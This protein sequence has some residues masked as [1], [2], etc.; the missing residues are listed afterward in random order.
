MTDHRPSSPERR[1]GGTTTQPLPPTTSP[2]G[3]TGIPQDN[4][5]DGD[6]D[7]NGAPAMATAMSY[8]HPTASPVA[9]GTAGMLFGLGRRCAQ[10]PFRVLGVWL[11][12]A[13]A[14]VSLKA[15]VG[16][17]LSDIFTV[18]GSQSQQAGA[19]L[20]ARFP[21][22]GGITGRVV[23]HSHAARLD[24]PRYETAIDETTQRLARSQDVIGVSNPFVTPAAALS[25]DGRTAF[26]DV[27]YRA[28]ITTAADDRAAVAAL[29]P[30][31]SAGIQAELSG[32]IA[33]AVNTTGRSE[34]IGL[35]AAVAVLLAV[36]GSVVA[37]GIPLAVALIGLLVGLSG[38]GAL[39]GF[40]DVP[41][42]ATTLAALVGLGVG[43]DYALFVVTRHRQHL[44]G[45]MTV[46]DA[47]GAANATAGRAVLLA[48]TTV[49]VAM[50]GLALAGIPAVTGMG[51]AVAI[52]V[53]VAMAAAVT[54]LPALLGLAGAHIDTWSVHGRRR[55]AKAAHRTA[56]GRW[57]GRVVAH[58]W[59]YALLSLLTLLALAAPVLGLRVGVP[60]DGSAPA[61]S[62]QRHAY[63]LLASGF[64][65][66]FNGPLEIAVGLPRPQDVAV[67]ARV[68]AGLALD[69]DIAAVSPADL[70]AAGDTAVVTATPRSAPQS[71]A[72]ADLVD[73]LRA[74]VL[75]A[76][77]AGSGARALVTGETAVSRDLSARIADRLPLFIAVV[78]ALSLLLLAAMFRS[79]VVPLEAAVMNLLSIGAAYGVVVATFQWGLAK[80]LLGLH[81]AVP[82]SPFVPLIMFAVLFGLSMD[83]EV[84]LLTRIRE[85]FLAHG[86]NRRSLIEG[87]GAT[88][89]VITSAALIMVAVFLAF[90]SGPLTIKMLSIGLASAIAIDAT[91]V[92]LVL[93]PA[94]M[95]LL[96]R[97]NWWLPGWLDRLVP[98]LEAGGSARPTAAVGEE[99][100]PEAA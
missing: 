92:R 32:S 36:F 78:I 29:A 15:A 66:G 50:A 96:G 70:N 59:R 60:D 28:R 98:Q 25:H 11:L 81:G 58:P 69:P 83:Y 19:L 73:R 35:A 38:V 3:T 41:S 20:A 85:A 52:A 62:T 65:H 53:A 48:G 21:S 26:V 47:A 61:A 57:V 14:A 72:T 51:E 94:T 67:L 17:T 24:T 45:G 93:V 97:A 12:A 40:T 6:R 84:F 43:I 91:L 8:P 77:V 16:A 87:A 74:R 90:L 34:I 56:T 99:P 49:V 39:A 9:R 46:T 42:T 64:G 86:D 95:A 10:H 79:I 100:E 5:G 76:S 75:P 80:S 37:M 7:R 1:A 54:L 23:L 89:R 33:D 88:G 71:G 44:A 31:R 63:D 55:H 18:P 4:G 27:R 68:R 13:V 82:V 2:P 22:Q 30:A